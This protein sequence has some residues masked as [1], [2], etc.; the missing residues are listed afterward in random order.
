MQLLLLSDSHASDNILDIMNIE[1][2]DIILHAGDFCLDD[3]NNI[4]KRIDY[5]V[6]GN[7]DYTT[8][9]DNLYIEIENLKVFLTHGH[10]YDLK[11]KIIN[12]KLTI[13]NI[14]KLIEN[15]CS[16]DIIVYGHTHVPAINIEHSQLILNPGSTNVSRGL[17]APSYMVVEINK[18]IAKIKLKEVKSN[19]IIM[20]KEYK[21]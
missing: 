14:D 5:K 9:E 19:K 16:S 8:A 2:P 6:R 10:M 21:L 13:E 4:I 20:E 1:N 11:A 7:C 3:E 15:S 12:D 18:D 17:T